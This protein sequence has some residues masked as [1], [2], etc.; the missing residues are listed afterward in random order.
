MQ[1]VEFISIPKYIASFSRRR[2]GRLSKNSNILLNNLGDKYLMDSHSIQSLVKQIKNDTY[3]VLEIGFGSGEHLMFLRKELLLSGNNQQYKNVCVIGCEPFISGV[4][5]LI[6]KLEISADRM[7]T[8]EVIGEM[9]QEALVKIWPDDAR[10]LIE[11][12]PNDLL[13]CVYI[14]FPDPWPKSKHH[15]RRLISRAFFSL[16]IPKIA[17]CGCII[18]AT[19]HYDY[20]MWI[21]DAIDHV[22]YVMLCKTTCDVIN[23]YETCFNIGINT[24]YAMKALNEGKDIY[25][26]T[27][28]RTV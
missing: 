17:I 1:E 26:F 11:N 5:K 21:L 15:K 7:H 20:A 8:K 19:D 12:I 14:L 16:I 13:N 18:I 4:V 28:M 27:I 24:R 10:L 3:C 6:K 22:A 25:Y 2:G 23:D 9:L